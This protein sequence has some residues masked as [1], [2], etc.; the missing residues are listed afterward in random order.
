MKRKR[1]LLILAGVLAALC[2]LIA[3]EKG[4]TRHVDRINTVDEII[5]SQAEADLTAV[6]WTQG[7]KTLAFRRGENGWSDAQDV[8]FPVSPEL[9]AEFLS[10]FSEV[11]ASFIIEDVADF[12]QYG[13]DSPQAI[14]TL[15]AG[16]EE[17]VLSLGGYSTM[18]AQ[19]YVTLG[20]GTVYLVDDD[21]L[22]YI[23]TDRD[24]FMMHDTVPVFDAVSE[25]TVSG[26]SQLDILYDPDT[27]HTYTDVCDWYE[28]SSGT[29]QPLKNSL[30]E[31]YLT[32]LT[33]LRLTD[34][35]TYTA[36]EEDLSPYGLASPERTYHLTGTDADGETVNYVLCVGAVIDETAQVEDD[37]EPVVNAYARFGD[38]D[39]IYHLGSATYET[40]AAGTLDSFRPTEVF[41]LDWDE[42][43]ALSVTLEGQ[44]YKLHSEIKEE[45]TEEDADR[46]WLLD[47]QEVST[48]S[49]Q[50]KIDA[51]KITDFT[52]EGTDKT[53]E[54]E[55]TV[56]LDNESYPSLTVQ[57]YRYDGESCLVLFEGE[58][59]GL[60]ERSRMVDLRE[61]MMSILLD[62]EDPAEA[63]E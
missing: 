60:V 4:I 33:S 43:T 15:T 10:H 42:V 29:Y 34:Y 47:G 25:L 12:G 54:L 3:L 18:D 17:H 35:A 26:D 5:L 7:D 27:V 22:E 46:I 61:A 19:R 56:F 16:E 52:S 62:M 6:S 28:I 37:E 45:E 9:M 20:D 13:L 32:T 41:S 14:V 21:L 1:K 38:S 49:L 39:I 31:S 44:T 50:S 2:G 40:L 24:E 11:H 57:I 23:T 55:L 30:V 48:F 53:L 51:L 58:V 36:S 59:L 8:A 63:E